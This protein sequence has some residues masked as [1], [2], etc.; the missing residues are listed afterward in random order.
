M[1]EKEIRKEPSGT[2][3]Q[4]I[5]IY[6]FSLFFWWCGHSAIDSE[7]KKLTITF[8]L[9]AGFIDLY[10]SG[11]LLIWFASLRKPMKE[12]DRFMRF[13]CI[14]GREVTCYKAFTFKLKG[15]YFAD[16]EAH[17]LIY[18]FPTGVYCTFPH[19]C[20][21]INYVYAFTVVY[22]NTTIGYVD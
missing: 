6:V 7:D 2:F 14:Y 5:L 10:A 20:H 13:M 22:S 11:W 15:F 9:I 1:N 4:I 19:A 16:E 3:L 8:W 17:A 12:N 18:E 21:N